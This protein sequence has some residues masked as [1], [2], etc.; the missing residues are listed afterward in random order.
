MFPSSQGELFTLTEKTGNIPTDLEIGD[1]LWSYLDPKSQTPQ[2]VGP[3]LN[4]LYALPISIVKVIRSGAL[5]DLSLIAQVKKHTIG[6][7]LTFAGVGWIWE[8]NR[9]YR[10]EG[11]S[12]VLK[13]NAAIIDQINGKKIQTLACLLEILRV[14]CEEKPPSFSVSLQERIHDVPFGPKKLVNY[15]FSGTQPCAFYQLFPNGAKGMRWEK[16]LNPWNVEDWVD[17]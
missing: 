1:V 5:I 2:L 9:L 13:E 6:S 11:N 7:F 3:N 14:I 8:N 10:N 15:Q 16:S 12:S 4:P 17:K